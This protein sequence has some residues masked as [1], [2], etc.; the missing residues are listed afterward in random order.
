[1][2]GERVEGE[3]KSD[4]EI[5][6][7]FTLH[8]ITIETAPWHIMTFTAYSFLTAAKTRSLKCPHSTR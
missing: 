6:F 4:E 3:A 8:V 5:L 2:C 7:C 1:M